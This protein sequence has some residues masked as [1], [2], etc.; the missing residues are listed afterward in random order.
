M[1]F[2]LDSPK[3]NLITLISPDSP[4]G[5][6]IKTFCSIYTVSKAMGNSAAVR[7]THLVSNFA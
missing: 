4:G 7:Y 3:G 6:Q 1:L 2:S 5:V